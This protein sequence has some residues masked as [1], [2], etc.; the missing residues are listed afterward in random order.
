MTRCV[1]CRQADTEQGVTTVT[2]HR[3]GHTVVVNEVP[4]LVC[5]NCGEAY[6]GEDEAGQVLS[7]AKEA[8]EAGVSVL[9]RDFSAA[10]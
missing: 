8:F 6:V 1:I 4:A 10:A 7:I 2:F 3:A 9:V 5:P